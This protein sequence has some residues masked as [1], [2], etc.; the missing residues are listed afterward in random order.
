MSGPFRHIGGPADFA[1]AFDVSRETVDRLS[2]YVALLEQWQPRINLV[3]GATLPDVWH[4]HIADSAQLYALAPGA[5]SWLDLGSGAGFPGLV[6][7]ILAHA[8]AGPRVALVESDRRKSAFL[9]EVA[10]QTGITVEIHTARIEQIATQSML[11]EVDVVSAR[12][13][14]PLE[15]LIPLSLPFMGE[16]TLGLFPKGRDVESEV[17][18]AR[19]GWEFDAELMPS[20]TDAEA[21]IVVIRRPRARTEGE[22]RDR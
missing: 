21:R 5:G 13:L 17:A 22:A 10:R 12:A 14:A 11:P 4:R 18:V 6:I 1:R 19:A 16:E 2:R 20:L 9:A 8:S 7:A 3:A 15:R